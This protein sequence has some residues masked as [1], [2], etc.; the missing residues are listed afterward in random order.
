M[1]QDSR[2]AVF[3]GKKRIWAIASIHGDAQRLQQL[4]GELVQ[5]F[6]PGDGL[7][8]LGNVMGYGQDVEATL[9]ELLTFRRLVIAQERA[10]VDDVVYLRGCQEEMLYKLR[11]L[12]FARDPEEVLLWM[13][14]QGVDATL[15][16]YDTS[17]AQGV[18]AARAGMSQVSAWMRA[19]KEAMA[20]FDGHQSYLDALKRAAFSADKKLLFV[21][22]NVDPNLP[23]DAQS[24]GFWWGTQDFRQNNTPFKGFQRTVRGYDHRHGGVHMADHHICL[25]GGSGFGGPLICACFD[26]DAMVVDRFEV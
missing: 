4:H 23:L 22:A 9:Y 14:S 10:D 6:V 25:D 5:R 24:D 18:E 1:S 12:S 8:Y 15:S 2:F 16:V 19:L 3:K 13:Q 20:R 11:Q 26:A 7:V 17:C 21:N